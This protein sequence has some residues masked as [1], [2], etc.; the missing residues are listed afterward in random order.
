M[1]KSADP[2]RRVMVSGST[3][4]AKRIC[5][6]LLAQGVQVKIIEQDRGRSY[7]IAEAMP[8]AIV[9]QGSP[10]DRDLLNEEFISDTCAFVAASEDEE[11][12]IL[13]ALLAK[14]LGARRTIALTD[15]A[16][17]LDLIKTI[18]VDVVVSPRLAAVSSI[19]LHV[20]R[21]R[22]LSVKAFGDEAEA[23]EFE[24]TAGSAVVGKPLRKVAM[25]SGSIVG[26][27][28]RDDAV[29]VPGGDDQVSPGDRVIVFALETA[30]PAVEN[31]FR[32]GG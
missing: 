5:L 26:A 8:K 2:V 4:V 18:G 20:R 3:T 21:G 22:V 9:L 15:K 31:L 32:A 25:P 27:I 13:S 1:G 10:T 11:E 16:S 28:V 29:I 6:E 14:R 7:A 24:A 19:L 12:N 23:L 30:V 17:Y